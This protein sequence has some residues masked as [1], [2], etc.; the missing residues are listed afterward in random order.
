MKTNQ[1]K[2]KILVRLNFCGGMG[3]RQPR[4]TKIVSGNATKSGY[5]KI[6]N[7]INIFLPSFYHIQ[8]T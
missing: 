3:N 8:T 5:K 4:Y 1:I 7:V 2:T 6:P